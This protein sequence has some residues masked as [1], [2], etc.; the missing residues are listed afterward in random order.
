MVQ[1]NSEMSIDIFCMDDLSV[2]ENGILKSPTT[3]MFGL[4]YLFQ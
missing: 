2:D 1:F 4:I 3:I